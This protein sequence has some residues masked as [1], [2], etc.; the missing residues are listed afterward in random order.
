MKPKSKILLLLEA[1]ILTGILIGFISQVSPPS[2]RSTPF[3][4][5]RTTSARIGSGAR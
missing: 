3:Q 2:D 5:A 1:L 4:L